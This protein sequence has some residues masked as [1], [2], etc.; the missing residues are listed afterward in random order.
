MLRKMRQ[1]TKSLNH[2][3]S[4]LMLSQ[5]NI[6]LFYFVTCVQKIKSSKG[7]ALRSLTAQ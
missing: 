6:N 3:C 7:T 1:I 5:G 2:N 4:H